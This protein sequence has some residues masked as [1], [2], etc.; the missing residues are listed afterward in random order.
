M[1]VD[2]ED[3]V[4]LDQTMDN[5][6]NQHLTFQSM[7]QSSDTFFCATCLQSLKN[8]R[9]HT[10]FPLYIFMFDELIASEKH[11][12][13]EENAEDAVSHKEE[14]PGV[15]TVFGYQDYERDCRKK[16]KGNSNIF[17]F[18][19][20][21]NH[22]DKVPHSDYVHSCFHANATAAFVHSHF[23]EINLII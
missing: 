22:N 18:K 4:N 9:I 2:D 8:L 5:D 13:V 12:N 11:D 14:L 19:Q 10:L 6:E 20:S 23:H 15:C 1:R 3:E 16:F 17:S 21:C 7:S